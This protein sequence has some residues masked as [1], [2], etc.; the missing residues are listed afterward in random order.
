M[1]NKDSVTYEVRI[2]ATFKVGLWN[3]KANIKGFDVDR[4]ML[5]KLAQREKDIAQKEIIQRIVG[6]PFSIT[7]E[8]IKLVWDTYNA[9]G[10]KVTKVRDALEGIISWRYIDTIIR[11][12]VTTVGGYKRAY[13]RNIPLD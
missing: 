7:D 2:M 5:T 12:K 6:R 9:N 8:V 1:N 11:Y 3:G 4:E 10:K 13:Y